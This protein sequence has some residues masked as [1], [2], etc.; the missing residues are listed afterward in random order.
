[1]TDDLPTHSHLATGEER[2]KDDPPEPVFDPGDVKEFTREPY[3][4]LT[5]DNVPTPTSHDPD[6]LLLT[7]PPEKEIVPAT[8]EDLRNLPVAPPSTA[9]ADSVVF[10]CVQHP[11]LIVW[12]PR[13]DRALGQFRNGY[14]I[15]DDQYAIDLLSQPT[16]RYVK[17]LDKAH[18]GQPVEVS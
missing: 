14:Y 15:T 6:T 2:G 9:S 12:D 4:D 5:V 3:A 11:S 17:R 1:M 16:Q 10:V 18:L 7:A 8:W 13:H